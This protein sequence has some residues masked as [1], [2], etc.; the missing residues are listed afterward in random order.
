MAEPP[1]GSAAPPSRLIGQARR[2]FITALGLNAVRIEHARSLIHTPLHDGAIL[3]GRVK[4]L[5]FHARASDAVVGT[6]L[7]TTHLHAL[8]NRPAS[9]RVSTLTRALFGTL[10]NTDFTGAVRLHTILVSLPAVIAKRT[11]ADVVVLLCNFHRKSLEATLL[12]GLVGWT[13]SA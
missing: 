8:K 11:E 13:T 3:K 12:T 2:K 5:T 6:L 4:L 9:F 10:T 1:I 7:V